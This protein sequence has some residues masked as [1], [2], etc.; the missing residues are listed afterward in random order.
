MN[1]AWYPEQQCQNDVHYELKRLAAKKNGKWRK[2][3]GKK[4]SHPATF[5][6]ARMNNRPIS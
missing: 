1:R 6:I 2:N 3:N 5:Q 4:I